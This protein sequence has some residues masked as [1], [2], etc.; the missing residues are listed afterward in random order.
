[1]VFKPITAAVATTV[2]WA[3][4][5]MGSAAGAVEDSYS[6]K[7]IYK[8]GDVGKYR[9]VITMEAD[10]PTGA[11]TIEF[12]ITTTERVKEMKPDG[13]AVV[14][15][16]VDNASM[17]VKDKLNT[18]TRELNDSSVV[19]TTYDGAGKE[20]KRDV[21]SDDGQPGPALMMLGLARAGVVPLRNMKVGEE[22]K[23]DIPPADAKS[24]RRAGS[25]TLVGLE[26][27]TDGPPAEGL[28]VKCVTVVTTPGSNG[29][30][31]VSIVSIVALDPMTAK[32][33][34][35][36]G[37]GSGKLGPLNAKKITIKQR[38]LLNK[39]DSK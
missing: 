19:T 36:D 35:V 4:F 32:V 20:L 24:S 16:R 8:A 38:L 17:Q 30:D 11:M 9:T 3:T 12:T 37:T 31:K 33:L 29:D 2:I 34:N 39:A 15:T 10:N 25:A 5:G 6:L 22:W 28:N 7:R 18:A 23:Y 21:S 27:R 13:G 14:E 1:M 26:K